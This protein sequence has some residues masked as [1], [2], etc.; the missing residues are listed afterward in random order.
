MLS[1]T[2]L[3]VFQ[4]FCESYLGHCVQY[5]VELHGG[6]FRVLGDGATRGYERLGKQKSHEKKLVLYTFFFF[7]LSHYV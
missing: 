2:F 1:S 4:F 7:Y 3:L 5:P 6:P